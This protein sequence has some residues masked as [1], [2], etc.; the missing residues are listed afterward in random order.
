MSIH[1]SIH[2]S[3]RQKL[4]GHNKLVLLYFVMGFINSLTTCIF[5]KYLKTKGRASRSEFWYFAI[6]YFG[7]I[8]LSINYL[9]FFL[10]Y[11]EEK[12]QQQ[13][14][15]DLDYSNHWGW[16][17]LFALLLIAPLNNVVIRRLHDINQSGANWMGAVGGFLI[18]GRILSFLGDFAGYVSGIGIL[19]FLI[20][21]VLCLK[22][23]DKKDNIYGKNIYKKQKNLI[24]KH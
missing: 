23:G 10:Q 14:R 17:M 1:F 18:L 9:D 19:V 6:F 5:K 11:L 2:L 15:V 7:V 24:R 8:A 3:V 4:I 12:N 13:F 22:V 21:L 20:V 16:V